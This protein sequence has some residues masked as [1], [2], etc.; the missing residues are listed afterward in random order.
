MRIPDF[1]I[2][3]TLLPTIPVG[4][5]LIWINADGIPLTSK[6]SLCGDWINFRS[7]GEFTHPLLKFKETYIDLAPGG[8]KIKESILRD[9]WLQ[10]NGLPDKWAVRG[11]KELMVYYI[12]NGIDYMA[13]DLPSCF[14][15]IKD[16]GDWDYFENIN[17][18]PNF[19]EI[20]FD[21]FK[22][23]Y[24]QNKKEK[25]E[26]VISSVQ[27]QNI[28]NNV[29]SDWKLKLAKMW[30]E[31]IALY[32]TI[33]VSC[34]LCNDIYY[35]ADTAQTKFL[36]TIFGNPKKEVD[37]TKFKKSSNPLLIYEQ[38]SEIP[39]NISC[40]AK[41]KIYLNDNTYKFDIERDGDALYLVI[42]YK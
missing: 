34:G 42:N 29:R 38:T 11:C 13:G 3:M 1:E 23:Y 25:M 6:L 20:T 9:L 31:D 40:Y 36:N 22:K 14:Y 37:L 35:D 41:N 27:A 4:T 12:K 28:I 5:E 15:Y 21:E 24:K 16:D 19:D 26:Y 33:K 32:K 39:F 18:L 30:G 8:N 2:N 10:Q 7:F 17:R